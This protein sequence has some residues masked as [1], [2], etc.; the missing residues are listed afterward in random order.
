M[1]GLVLELQRDALD[2]EAS[3]ANLLRKA[4]V[5]SKKLG[6][7]DIELWLERELHGYYKAEVVEIPD[8]RKVTGQIKA[9]DEYHVWQPVHIENKDLAEQ[10]CCRL[11]SEPISELSE[12]VRN[13]S[14]Y[15][16]EQKF[17]PNLKIKIMSMMNYQTEP[18]FQFSSVQI[19]RMLDTVKTHVLSWALELE[20]QGITGE[21]M[22]FSRE[23]KQVASRVVYQITNN[24][25]NMHNSQLQQDSAGAS[26]NLTVTYENK[27]LIKLLEELKSSFEQLELS[28]AAKNE[29]SA[30][31]ATIE[32]Q[33]ASPNPKSIIIN[34]SLKSSRAILEGITGSVLATGLLQQICTFIS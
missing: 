1:A 2:N 22:S 32:M 4:M 9:L 20:E 28:A 31:V 12:L 6:I 34:E 21:G 30:E 16:V 3:I 14:T 33:L 13:D 26:Q 19:H 7:E 25:Q 11:M 8:Y 23:E 15:A 10:L 18:V 5:V 24:I 29:L 17:P 27:D